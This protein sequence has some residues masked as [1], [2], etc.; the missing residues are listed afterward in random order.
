MN[1]ILQNKKIEVVAIRG[2]TENQKKILKKLR[3]VSILQDQENVEFQ[4]RNLF[5]EI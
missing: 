1:P 2:T 3:Q 5:S 4:T